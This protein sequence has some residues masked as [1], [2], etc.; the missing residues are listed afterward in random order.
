[1]NRI[2]WRVPYSLLY[3]LGF[4]PIWSEPASAFEI[5]KHLAMTTQKMVESGVPGSAIGIIGEG[6]ISPDIDGCVTYGYCPFDNPLVTPN[7]I[8]IS[9]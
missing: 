6:V 5:Q 7:V 8:K 3:L 1:M 4:I 2:T 9:S